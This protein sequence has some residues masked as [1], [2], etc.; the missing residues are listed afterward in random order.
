MQISEKLIG[1]IDKAL[2]EFDSLDFRL[3]SI[4]RNA[5][6]IA[7]L[8]N[9][10]DS[11]WWM[12]M[13]MV[14]INK[15]T[16]KQITEEIQP[17]YSEDHFRQLNVQI[18]KKYFSERKI[19]K[20][21]QSG[22][23]TRD[24]ATCILSVPEIERKVKTLVDEVEKA[25]LPNGLQPFDLYRVRQANFQIRTMAKL[26]SDDLH[27]ILANVGQ[28]VHKF[29]SISEKQLLYGQLN[30]D[31]F[32]KNRQYVEA[33]L[34]DMA[35]ESLEQLTTAY[36]RV[37]EGDPESRIHA[38]TSCRRIMK[39][40]SDNVYPA[41]NKEIVGSDGKTR[42]MSDEKYIA[43][44]WQF[45]ADKVGS[46]ASGKLMLTEINDL[47]HR[48]DRIYDLSC[49]GIHDSVS[50]FEVNQC[51]IQTYLLLGDILRLA[52]EN[53]AVGIEIEQKDIKN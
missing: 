51:V 32:E 41:N 22:N 2:S 7:R 10:F 27:S 23:I 36:G 31:I 44:L 53:S 8:R 15:E 47:G 37:S 18:V 17:H 21:D 3:S 38:L 28:R 1:L 12:E 5:I 26:A 34:T 9:D 40:L 43:R 4:I 20:M 50:E 29:L 13:E 16:L 52:D 35:P 42:K 25:V 46:K 30:S 33:R 45:V 39:S 48:I 19:N 14:I 24:D 6:R 49:K 11:L